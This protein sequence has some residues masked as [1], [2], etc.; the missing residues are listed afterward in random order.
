M[1]ED[2]AHITKFVACRGLNIIR[3]HLNC[4]VAEVQHV[5][6][7]VQYHKPGISFFSPDNGEEK[8]PELPQWVLV[9][10]LPAV[11]IL[12]PSQSIMQR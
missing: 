8:I 5:D 3:L 12:V 10:A 4:Y 7:A 1:C 2:S 6:Y 11:A 9:R